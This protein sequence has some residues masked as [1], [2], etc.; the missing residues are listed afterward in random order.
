MSTLDPEQR[1]RAF[2]TDVPAAGDAA[3]ARAREALNKRIAGAP[4]ARPRAP[5]R[6]TAVL[7]AGAGALALA[8]VIAVVFGLDSGGIRSDPTAAQALERVARVAARQPVERTLVGPGQYWYVRS[9][10][11]FMTTV[12]DQPPYSA[13]T[14]S[15][16]EIWLGH[17]RGG[18][19]YERGEKP[20]FFGARD[21]MRWRAAGSPSLTR[22]MVTS[23]GASPA[24]VAFGSRS[25]TFDELRHLPTDVD[26]LSAQ[27]KSA[28]GGAGPGPNQ[29]AF[30][31]IGDLLREA[32]VPPAVR[33]ALYRAAARIHGVRFV[34][35]VRDPEGREG[36]AVALRAGDSRRELIFDPDTS[37]LLAEREV[38]VHRVKWLDAPAGTVIGSA[39][40]LKSGVVGS[41]HER[42]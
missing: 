29:E 38:L 30:T 15:V 22:N 1:L 34:G 14:P 16:R 37:A 9:R 18:R 19:L 11:A 35:R 10:T 41:T 33:A 5:R 36:L 39:A 3:R 8:L 27:I 2:R 7:A 31:V 13:I 28:A 42:P 23:L 4:H 12:G 40:Y 20:Q 32:P 24:T 25:L 21:R 17:T 26:E 6:R